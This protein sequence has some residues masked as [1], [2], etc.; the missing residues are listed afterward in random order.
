M[1]AV[2]TV[3][4]DAEVSADDLFHHGQ[5]KFPGPVQQGIVVEGEI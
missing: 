5:G 4:S 1:E 3:K 2:G